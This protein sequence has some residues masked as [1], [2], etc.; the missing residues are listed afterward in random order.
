[1]FR[2]IGDNPR[3]LPQ[4]NTIPRVV[5]FLVAGLD[6]EIVHLL[7]ILQISCKKS[8]HNLPSNR[9]VNLEV[10]HER[11]GFYTLIGFFY[12]FDFKLSTH[13]FVNM[14]VVVVS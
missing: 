12:V 13:Y 5:T 11:I 7:K 9:P 3:W 14:Y 10:M 8:T 6:S 4:F 2:N 1:M